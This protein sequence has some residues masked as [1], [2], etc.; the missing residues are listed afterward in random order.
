[1]DVITALSYGV[2]SRS[3]TIVLYG[4]P[5]ILLVLFRMVYLGRIVAGFG[6]G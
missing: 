5:C 2:L 6:V 1:M 3:G 4:H